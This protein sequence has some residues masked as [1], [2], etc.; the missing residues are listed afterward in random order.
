MAERGR[1]TKISSDSSA[2]PVFREKLPMREGMRTGALSEPVR[3]VLV[4]L[5]GQEAPK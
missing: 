1:E 5:A 3:P 2:K 4:G